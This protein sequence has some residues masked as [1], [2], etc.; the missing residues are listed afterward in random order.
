M[1]DPDPSRHFELLKQ[2]LFQA[3]DDATN[4]LFDEATDWVAALPTLQWL[5]AGDAQHASRRGGKSGSSSGS[6]SSASTRSATA[7]GMCVI[8]PRIC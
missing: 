4:T 5:E 3:L 7:T 1:H 6:V 2:V 8:M